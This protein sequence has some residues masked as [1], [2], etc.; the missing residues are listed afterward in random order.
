MQKRITNALR[1][2]HLGTAITLGIIISIS[3]A[4]PMRMLWGAFAVL[5]ALIVSYRALYVIKKPKTYS[6]NPIDDQV[7]RDLGI[8]D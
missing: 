3:E 1:L 5:I 4:A 2:A 8:K 7:R 6:D